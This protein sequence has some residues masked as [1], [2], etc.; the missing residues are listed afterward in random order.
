MLR[1]LTLAL[2]LMLAVVRVRVTC[3]R[4][5]RVFVE[6]REGVGAR[7]W[8]GL[9]LGLRLGLG[10]GLVRVRVRVRASQRVAS[11]FTPKEFM[12]MK[13]LT[14]TLTLTHRRSSSA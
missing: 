13:A 11:V 2:T 4:G 9:G 6:V 14:L 7:G 1:I 10:L 3:L 8:L 12:S 5:Q